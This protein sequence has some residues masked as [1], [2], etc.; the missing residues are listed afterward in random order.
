MNVKQRQLE[1]CLQPAELSATPDELLHFG[2]K[3]MLFSHQAKAFLAANPEDNV[4]KAHEGCVLTTTPNSTPCVRNVFEIVRV[5]TNDG[6]AETDDVVHYEQNFRLRMEPFSKMQ[7]PSYMHSEHVTALASAKYSRH[8]EVSVIACPSGETVFQLLYPDSATRFEMQG[9][10]VPA[11]SPLVVRHVATGSF[12]ASDEIAYQNI[13]GTEFEVHCF[14]YYSLNKTQ[15]LTSE[16]KGDITSDYS[17]R[18]HGLPNI[19]TVVTDTHG[20]VESETVMQNL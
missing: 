1:E 8:Q 19:W 18:R 16:K 17:L 2:S 10:G 12:L 15:N 3:V 4:V 9:E 14:P 6:Y 11:G 7:A 5:A 20:L 13:F